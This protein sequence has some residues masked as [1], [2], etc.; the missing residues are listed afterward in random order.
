M[1]SHFIKKKFL[2]KS[3]IHSPYDNICLPKNVMWLFTVALLIIAKTGSK[4][5]SIK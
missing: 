2:I 4:K 1:V 3:I 5:M